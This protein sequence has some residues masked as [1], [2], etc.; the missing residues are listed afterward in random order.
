MTGAV[1]T[2]KPITTAIVP[3]FG[4]AR[5]MAAE[6]GKLLLGSRWVGIPFAGAMP[7]VLEVDAHTIV[8]NDLHRHVVN[9]ARVMAH[10]TSGPKLY[11]MLRRVPFCEDALDRSQ[12]WLKMH[13]WPAPEDE[14][15]LDAAFHYFIACWMGRSGKA[16]TADEFNGGVSVRWNCNG[17]D[18]NARYRSAVKSLIAWRRVLQK[19][20]VVSMDCFDFLAKCEDLDRYAIYCDPPFPGPGAKYRHRFSED[21]HR[22]LAHRLAEFR[23]AMVVCRFYR[24]PLIEELYPA[25]LWQWH[26]FT[27]R[28]QSNGDAPEVLLTNDAKGRL[29]A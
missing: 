11:R 24:H 16:G 21:D 9:L 20:N 8:A 7:E 19:V 26:E 5:M 2:T 27:G 4:C 23:R 1:K 6:V 18:S 10:P 17:G 29:F 3:Y 28:K 22:R 13:D 15:D 25:G 14:Y 12:A